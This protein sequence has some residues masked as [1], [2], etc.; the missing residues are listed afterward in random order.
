MQMSRCYVCITDSLGTQVYV[1]RL[2]L[3]LGL[4]CVA[5]YSQKQLIRRKNRLKN[6]LEAPGSLIYGVN[7]KLLLCRYMYLSSM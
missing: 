2:M 3:H 7:C 5:L 1:F 6:V 4:Y